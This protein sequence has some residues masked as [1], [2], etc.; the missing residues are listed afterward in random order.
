MSRPLFCCDVIRLSQAFKLVVTQ[1]CWVACFLVATWNLGQDQVF[2]L[3]SAILVATSKV[4]RDNSFFISSHNL[5]FKSQ[6]FPSLFLFLVATSLFC[7]VLEYM[8][9]PRFDA[10]TLLYCFLLHFMSRPQKFVTTSFMLSATDPWSQLPFS[11]CDLKLFCLFIAL[12]Q[13]GI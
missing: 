7:F 13:R 3:L 5:I 6:Q 10:E 1:N 11:C 12:S 2:S 9:R 8:S 4:C